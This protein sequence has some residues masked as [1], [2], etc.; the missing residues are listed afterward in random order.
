MLEMKEPEP[1]IP[2]TTS[3]DTQQLQT[4]CYPQHR[5]HGTPPPTKQEMKKILDIEIDAW[6]IPLS[7]LFGVIV[8]FS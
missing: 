8:C 1:F 2:S 7:L 5:H 3:S 6:C 4:T